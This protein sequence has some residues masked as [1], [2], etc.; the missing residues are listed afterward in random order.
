[1]NEGC[2]LF[3]S[4]FNPNF[5]KS[6]D[7]ELLIETMFN[8]NNRDSLIYWLEFKND[9]VF[10]T[11]TYGNISGGSSFK[12]VMFKRKSGK[13]VTGNPQNPTILTTDEAVQLGRR[14]RDSLVAGAELI[15]NIDSNI[16]IKEYIKLQEDLDR[17]L[18]ENMSNLGWVHKYYHMLYPEKIDAFHSTKW[19]KHTL[20]C[21]HIKPIDDSKLYIMSGQ[22]MEIVKELGLPAAHAM[23]TLAIFLGHLGSILGLMFRAVLE[24][25]GIL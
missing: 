8:I 18:I 22:Y 24:I 10:K 12:Y 13:W 19:Q 1:L 25:I 17:V 14:L 3:R 21:C 11:N 16:S 6:I 5:L 4:K 15:E 20:I 23:K 7:G 9:D 2:S